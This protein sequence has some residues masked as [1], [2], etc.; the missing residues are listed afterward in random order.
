M[1]DDDKIIHDIVVTAKEQQPKFIAIVGAPIPYMIGTD[2]E[3]IARIVTKQTGIPAF[4]FK[5][6]GMRDYLRGE[7]MAL[8]AIIKEFCCKKEKSTVLKV[9]ILGA[10]PMDFSM[11][12]SIASIQEWLKVN[13]CEAGTCFTMG[14]MLEDIKSAA[15]ATV[16]LVISSGAFQAAQDME[17]E[18]G[19]PYVVG[20]P[21]GEK[22]CKY[23]MD[24]IKTAADTKKSCIAINY[25]CSQECKKTFII[26]EYV[27]SASLAS[28]FGKNAVVLCPLE[29]PEELFR[30]GDVRDVT[31]DEIAAL[32]N[33]DCRIIADPFYKVL[34]GDNVRFCSLPHVAFSGR[35]YETLIPDLICGSLVKLK[36]DKMS[37]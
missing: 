16:N 6:N 3:A 5:T 1:G 22:F 21:V 26:G 17:Q 35:I 34:F 29:T 36:E 20:V 33:C 7:S 11:N 15:D 19:I 9:N 8:R 25:H 12:H 10:T 37:C 14:C 18:F 28:E 30:N 27:F 32:G 23:L 2:F 31:E 13:G 24:C 4:G